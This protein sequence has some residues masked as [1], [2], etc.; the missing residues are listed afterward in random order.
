MKVINKLTGED[1]SSLYL[2]QMQGEITREE[3]IKLAGLDPEVEQKHY[4][5]RV[6][7][8]RNLP[9]TATKES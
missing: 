2:K 5:E 6:H 8:R 7:N 1:V 3:F 4:E 9:P